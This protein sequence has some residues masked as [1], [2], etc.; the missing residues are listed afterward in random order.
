MSNN[1]SK[2]KFSNAHVC[3]MNELNMN[4]LNVMMWAFWT[5]HTLQRRIRQ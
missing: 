5:E 2:I 1:D 3:F 4:E